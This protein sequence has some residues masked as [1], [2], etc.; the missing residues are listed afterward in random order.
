MNFEKAYSAGE[1]KLTSRK[2][3]YFM[4]LFLGLAFMAVQFELWAQMADIGLYVSAGIFP[5]LLYTLTWVHA[6]HIVMA[7]LALL[8]L[9][10]SVFK[11]HSD[12]KIIWILNI[13][14]FWH[15]LGVIWLIMFVVIFAF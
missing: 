9:L 8:L 2:V 15:F 11:E 6:A 13:G 12:T 4:T 7:I 3:S 14:K 5:S 10:P 1:S